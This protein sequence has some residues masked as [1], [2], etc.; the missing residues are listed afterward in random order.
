MNKTD[1][2]NANGQGYTLS[3][4]EEERGRGIDGAAGGKFVQL[5]VVVGCSGS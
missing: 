5:K 2:I 1:R 3:V 4:F